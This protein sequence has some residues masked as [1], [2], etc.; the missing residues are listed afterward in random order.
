MA[1]DLPELT[2]GDQG[3]LGRT[4][5]LEVSTDVQVLSED[6]VLR[7]DQGLRVPGLYFCVDKLRFS[8]TYDYEF[9]IPEWITLRLRTGELVSGGGCTLQTLPYP[10]RVISLCFM[11]SA[12]FLGSV[13]SSSL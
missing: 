4:G 11:I 3:L 8:D 2:T 12:K 6:P 13:L 7:K 10:A 1:L 9:Y 5:D